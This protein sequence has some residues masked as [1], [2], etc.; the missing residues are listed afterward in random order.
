[1]HKQKKANLQYSKYLHFDKHDQKFDDQ[2]REKGKK[3]A[4]SEYCQNTEY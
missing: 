1:M 2:D 3:I 4:F